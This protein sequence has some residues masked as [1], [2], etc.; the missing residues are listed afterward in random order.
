VSGHTVMGA[1]P[2]APSTTLLLS[3]YTAIAV[4]EHSHLLA[5]G[6]LSTFIGICKQVVNC[7]SLSFGKVCPTSPPT[8]M[9]VVPHAFADCMVFGG[10]VLLE[11]SADKQGPGACARFENC[12]IFGSTFAVAC[13]TLNGKACAT[14]HKCTLQV[15][16]RA[17]AGSGYTATA[18]VLPCQWLHVLG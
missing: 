4:Y 1:A 18:P 5:K 3:S 13:V 11:S 14:L 16:L 6:V 12:H 17:A 10:R 7:D 8:R 2:G 15:K 9:S